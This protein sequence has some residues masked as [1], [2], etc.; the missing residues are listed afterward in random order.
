MF[1]KLIVIFTTIL[2]AIKLSEEAFTWCDAYET[3]CLFSYGIK[4]NV[5]KLTEAQEVCTKVNNN[6]WPIEITSQ[7]VEDVLKIFLR[8]ISLPSNV[9]VILNAALRNNEWYWIKNNL[10]MLNFVSKCLLICDSNILL[11]NK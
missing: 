2:I 5:S 3:F 9:N 1:T 6:S 8:N 4:V 10:S 7:H 11:H